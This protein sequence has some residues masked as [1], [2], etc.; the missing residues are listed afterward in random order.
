MIP[1]IQTRVGLPT[2][3]ADHL[4]GGKSS[5]ISICLAEVT[6]SGLCA[7]TPLEAPSAPYF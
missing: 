3:A 6:R 4:P 5:Y 7:M 1:C 2:T